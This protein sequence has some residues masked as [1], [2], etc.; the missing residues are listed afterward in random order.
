MK[1]YGLNGKLEL[2]PCGC[3]AM[4]PNQD[5]QFPWRGKNIKK[6]FKKR[7]KHRERQIAKILELE[8]M[9]E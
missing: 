9:Y 8:V 7:A 2:A 5:E 1:P 3:C 4:H 6:A